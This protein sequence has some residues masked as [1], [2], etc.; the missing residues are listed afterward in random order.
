MPDTGTLL[1][2]GGVIIIVSKSIVD[3]LICTIGRNGKGQ[4][5][6]G[7]KLIFYRAVSKR[8]NSLNVIG[9][10]NVYVG[11]KVIEEVCHER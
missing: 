9:S 4:N 8:K 3:V 2:E 10:M 6:S 5:V 1:T 7:L 11:R